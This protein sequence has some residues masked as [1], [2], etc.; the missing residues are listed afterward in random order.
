MLQI[1]GLLFGV[2]LSEIVGVSAH[3]GEKWLPPS[4]VGL[5]LEH[6]ESG[7]TNFPTIHSTAS[8][9]GK[10]YEARRTLK[11]NVVTSRDGKISFSPKVLANSND[12]ILYTLQINTTIFDTIFVLF[13]F[14]LIAILLMLY[15]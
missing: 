14:F 2:L 10:E 15:G 12:C 4:N 8:F 6:L 3:G 9:R 7:S 13:N 1:F 5:T 11:S